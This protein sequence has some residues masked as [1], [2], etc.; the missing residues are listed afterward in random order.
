MSFTYPT[1]FLFR[2][3]DANPYNLQLVA[4]YPQLCNHWATAAQFQREGFNADA[5]AICP[6]NDGTSA[7]LHWNVGR[8]IN[9][10]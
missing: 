2:H 8:T 10:D 4:G 3:L 9:A 7:A 1:D 6:Y 5:G